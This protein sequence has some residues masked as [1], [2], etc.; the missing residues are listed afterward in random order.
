MPL[1][2]VFHQ[3]CVITEHLYQRI[4]HIQIIRN[5]DDPAFWCVHASSGVK[6]LPANII[7]PADFEGRGFSM[8]YLLNNTLNILDFK[9]TQSHCLNYVYRVNRMHLILTSWFL[10]C[11]DAMMI[12][13]LCFARRWVCGWKMMFLSLNHL[14][15][16]LYFFYLYS[17]TLCFEMTAL[18]YFL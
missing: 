17:S 3:E 13:I 18:V 5:G 8:V 4:I 11:F 2:I 16:A 10:Y 15:I 1:L 7:D 6:G 9:A 14:I 12:V